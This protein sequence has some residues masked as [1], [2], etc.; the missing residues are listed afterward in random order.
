[1]PVDRRDT[2]VRRTMSDARVSGLR[3]PKSDETEHLIES[4]SQ[5]CMSDVWEEWKNGVL[6]TYA[7]SSARASIRALGSRP[8]TPDRPLRPTFT[9]NPTNAAAPRVVDERCHLLWF[10]DGAR[11]SA[12]ASLRPQ[13]GLL[14]TEN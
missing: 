5:F 8:I 7:A 10:V 4:P 9:A 6:E 2:S 1:M 13:P 11:G 3:K 14:A 12:C